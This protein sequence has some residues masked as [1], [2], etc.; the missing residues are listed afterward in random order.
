MCVAATLSVC[1]LCTTE[2]NMGVPTT[3]NS[4]AHMTGE[5]IH[6]F[7]DKLKDRLNPVQ[8]TQ[9][10]NPNNS[11]CPDNVETTL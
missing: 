1:K 11:L 4:G 9:M 10:E 3:R 2:I 6:G 7:E 8:S 5:I